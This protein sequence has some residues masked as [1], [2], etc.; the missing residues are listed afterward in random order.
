MQSS[1]AEAL[2]RIDKI[3]LISAQKDDP[4]EYGSQMRMLQN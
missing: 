4:V 1:T 2:A 3:I